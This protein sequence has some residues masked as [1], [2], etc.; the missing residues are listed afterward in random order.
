MIFFFLPV[1]E[2]ESWPQV[3]ALLLGMVAGTAFFCVLAIGFQYGMN[4]LDQPHANMGPD[5][6]PVMTAVQWN[7]AFSEK[8]TRK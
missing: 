2:I 4:S 1:P 3:F 7:A 5:M 6:M 8:E